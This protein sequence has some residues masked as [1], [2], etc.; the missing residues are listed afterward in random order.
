MNAL[1]DVM[2]VAAM[3]M[4]VRGHYFGFFMTSNEVRLPS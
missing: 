2:I 4:Q 3:A 1:A